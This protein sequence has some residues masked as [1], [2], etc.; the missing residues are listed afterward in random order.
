MGRTAEYLTKLLGY[1]KML[2]MNTGVEAGETSV[3][4]AR[5]WG[6][7]V[8]GIPDNKAEVVMTNGNFWGRSITASG[9]CND[10]SR[11]KHFGPF[12]PGFPLVDYN[13]V[14]AVKELFESNPNICGIMV[15]AIQGDGG[16]IVPDTNYLRSI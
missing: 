11:Y 5:R 8:K 12:T 2:P 15:E 7:V 6:Y 10:P 16:I 1:D 14:P 4:L 13:D 9:A 3:K